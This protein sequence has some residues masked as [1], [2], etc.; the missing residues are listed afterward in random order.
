M[1]KNFHIFLSMS[2]TAE[3][4]ILNIAA[5]FVLDIKNIWFVFRDKLCTIIFNV[6]ISTWRDMAGWHG[7]RLT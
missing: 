5:L 2:N 1:Q 6:V 7:V 3:N 4:L